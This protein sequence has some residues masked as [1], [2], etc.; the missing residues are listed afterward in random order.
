MQFSG[1]QQVTKETSYSLFCYPQ[2][3]KCSLLQL[4]SPKLYKLC[5][6]WLKD[7]NGLSRET[8]QKLDIYRNIMYLIPS[9]GDKGLG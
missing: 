4:I 1:V 9:L 6:G 2:D 7:G 5:K 8:K 3:K